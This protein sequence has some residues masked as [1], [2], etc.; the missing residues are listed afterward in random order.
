MMFMFVPVKV[1]WLCDR[2]AG[3]IAAGIKPRLLQVGVLHH[4]QQQQRQQQEKDGEN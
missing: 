2:H 4:Q 1:A 3:Y